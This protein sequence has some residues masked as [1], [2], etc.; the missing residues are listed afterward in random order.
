MGQSIGIPRRRWGIGLLLGR[1][2]AGQ[3]FRSGQSVRRRTATLGRVSPEPDRAWAS[4][5]RLCL[6]LCSVADPG[7]RGA[8]SAGRDA[9]RTGGCVSVGRGLGADGGGERLRRHFR[10]PAAARHCR[11]ADLSGQC[12]GDRLLVSP[13]RTGDGHGHLR[14]CRQVLQRHRRAGRGRG[15]HAARLALGVHRHRC[16]ELDLFH[17]LLGAVSRPECGQASEPG[18]TQLYPGRRRSGGRAIREY[19][20]HVPLFARAAEDLGADD[21]LHGL[22]LLVLFVPDLAAWLPGAGDAHGH[23]EVRV[24]RRD[25]LDVRHPCPTWWSVAG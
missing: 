9:G 17:R 8:R 5:Q 20:Q 11:G 12:E 19:R 1:G 4:V 13:A 25:S 22:W 18:G 6:D 3:L 7:R 23:P 14:R 16:L 15:R 2:C 10:G 24:L 21:W